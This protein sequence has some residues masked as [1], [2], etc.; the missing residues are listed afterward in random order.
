MKFLVY[1]HCI[2][3]RPRLS[4][5]SFIKIVY[6]T[7]FV[8]FLSNS[9]IAQQNRFCNISIIN[10]NNEPVFLR[11]EIADSFESR[12]R[13]LMFRKMLKKNSGML[14]VFRKEEKRNFWMKDT[15]I[16]L[17]IAFI[18]RYGVINEIYYMKPLDTSIIYP[19]LLPAQY[20]LEVNKGWFSENKIT[21][22][23]K[24]ILNG[25]IGK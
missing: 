12:K 3:E 18:N 11:V 17:D 6:L 8:L 20:V 15:F 25:C 7:F 9:T 1:P 4:L 23:C 13:G 10:N 21:V 24:L 14:F 5:K 2:P 22:G 16:P 19:S